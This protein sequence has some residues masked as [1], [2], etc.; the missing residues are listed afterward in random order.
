MGFRG[1]I[2]S[3]ESAVKRLR[4]KAARSTWSD[5][6]DQT[7]YS[8]EALDEK[9][10]LVRAFLERV[11]PANAWDL[12]AN[13]GRFSRIAADLGI[14]TV[15][16]DVDALAVEHHYQALR[17][18]RDTRV[19]PLVMDLANPSPAI[20]WRNNER[21]AFIERGPVD[22]ALAL[23][24]IHHLAIANN[25]PLES[26]ARFFADIARALIIEFVPKS[27]SQVAP[28]LATREDI[29]GDYTREGFEAAF[30]R[31]FTIE[32]SE[33]IAGAERTLYLMRAR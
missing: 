20:G 25:V 13:T 30:G 32:A 5:Y 23:A 8:A 18:R 2:D 31:V 6:Y 22:V 29:F 24:L 15:A 28:M 21:R 10:R 7:N 26:S 16:A 3:L 27:D 14:R 17:S 12:G 4:W 9:A 33:R 1:I 11:K 19:L